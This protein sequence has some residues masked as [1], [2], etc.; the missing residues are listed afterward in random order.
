[1]LLPLDPPMFIASMS[2]QDTYVAT[3]AADLCALIAYPPFSSSAMPTITVVSDWPL[4]T[5][6]SGYFGVGFRFAQVPVWMW[7]GCGSAVPFL[8]LI[9]TLTSFAP[10]A[11]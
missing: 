10:T 6:V 1:M 7:A 4:T 9:V 2:P 11:W 5:F 8:R 3:S